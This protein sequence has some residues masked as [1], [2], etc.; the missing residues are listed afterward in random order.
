MRLKSQLCYDADGHDD[1]K[2]HHDE[3]SCNNIEIKNTVVGFRHT[4]LTMTDEGFRTGELIEFH[5]ARNARI[6]DYVNGFKRVLLYNVANQNPNGF[7]VIPSYAV[8]GVIDYLKSLKGEVLF[9][10]RSYKSERVAVAYA[11]TKSG[12]TDLNQLLDQKI[13][14]FEDG[15]PWGFIL[16]FALICV[17]PLGFILYLNMK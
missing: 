11:F 14:E 4:A 5:A 15:D 13:K 6:T 3:P 2:N 17:I 8:S 12:H 9:E 10:M 1:Q 7:C 16:V